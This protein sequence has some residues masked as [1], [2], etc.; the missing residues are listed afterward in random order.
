MYMYMYSSVPETS[1]EHMLSHMQDPQSS[2]H[3]KPLSVVSPSRC[4]IFKVGT[5][6]NTH[7]HIHVLIHCAVQAR[8]LHVIR[9][10][11]LALTLASSLLHLYSV[12]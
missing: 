10:Y 7:T 11:E 6:T 2:G 3:G 9:S 1:K 4:N 5:H 8:G 12:L